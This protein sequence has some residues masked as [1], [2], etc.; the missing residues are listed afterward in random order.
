MPGIHERQPRAKATVE[1]KVLKL[2]L[3]PIFSTVSLIRATVSLVGSVLLYAPQMINVSSSPMPNMMK[4]SI[5]S[6]VL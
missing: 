3:R 2:M 4:G 1:V 6:I 5:F